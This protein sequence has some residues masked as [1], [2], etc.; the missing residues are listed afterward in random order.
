MEAEKSQFGHSVDQVGNTSVNSG[1]TE[2]WL[3]LRY[4]FKKQSI[5]ELVAGK[6]GC[7]SLGERNISA[8]CGLV[9]LVTK[10]GWK[11]FQF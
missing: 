10:Q 9:V 3:E 2:W 7:G 11:V 8:T 1:N 5:E 4:Y 6:I